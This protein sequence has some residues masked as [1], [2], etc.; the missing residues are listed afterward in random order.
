MAEGE[1]VPNDALVQMMTAMREEL[2]NMTQQ[3]GNIRQELGARI[4]RVEAQP[5]RAPVRGA[6]VQAGDASD[7]EEMPELEDEFPPD[8][9][10]HRQQRRPDPLRRN[11]ARVVDTREQT[12]DLKLTPPTFSGQSDPEAYLDWERRLEHIFEC[13]GYAE[14]KKVAVAAAQLTDNALAWWDR[15]VAER[16]RQRFGPVVTWSDMKFL[17]RLRYVP[18]HYHRDL[19]KRFRKLSLGNRSVDEYFEEFEKLM[20]SLELEESEEALMAQFIDGLQE[21]IARKVERAQYSG[22]HELL[23]LAVQ[24]EQQIKRKTALTSRN[25]TSQ[26]WNASSSKLVDKGKAVEIESRFKGK[27]TESPKFN[28]AEQ[29]KPSNPTSRTRDIT[30]FRCQGRGHMSRECPNQRVMII[31]PCGD[32]ES[33]DE[34]EDESNDLEE[35]VEYPDTG[36]LLVTRRVLSV[37]VHPEETAQRENIFHTRCT[38]KNKVCNLI[39]DGGSCTNVA[40]KYMVDRLG[41]EKT[42][43]P[44]PYKLRWLND[45]TELKISEQVSIPFSIGKYHD[46]VTCDVVPMQAGHL[47]LG[48]PWQFDRATTHN[49]RTNHYFFMYKERKYN[50]APLSPTE[51]HEM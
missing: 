18:E 32:Y 16:R 2:R 43:H 33:Q 19:Q 12:H 25:R 37:L 47:L 5:R 35:E 22:L 20:N 15:N 36:E 31:T 48:R 10:Q 7:D 17:L 40:S 34:Q 30:C 13:Y 42:K 41:L 11:P 27:G 51:V 45:Q 24:V 29:G 44:C 9:L 50:L 46:Q 38:V 28:R 39:I 26:P 49:G 23:H 3:M 6:Q 4:D 1:P 8:P 21:R 14:R